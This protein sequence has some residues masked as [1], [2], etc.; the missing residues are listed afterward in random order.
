MEP[1]NDEEKL[2]RIMGKENISVILTNT[3]HNIR[4]LTGGYFY[5]FHA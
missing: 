5:H 4:Y 1:I 2:N 3:R